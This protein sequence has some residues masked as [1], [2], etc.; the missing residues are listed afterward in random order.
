MGALYAGGAPT[1]LVQGAGASTAAG[2]DMNSFAGRSM[3]IGNVQVYD[4]A[5]FLTMNL[6]NMTAG[7]QFL[8][9]LPNKITEQIE[10]ERRDPM[11]TVLL[12]MFRFY[13]YEILMKRKKFNNALAVPIPW[14]GIANLL[15][16]SV[17]KFKASLERKGTAF[18][19]EGDLIRYIAEGKQHFNDEL[20]HIKLTVLRTLYKDCCEEIDRVQDYK[21]TWAKTHRIFDKEPDR[22]ER[23]E[24]REFGS[25]QHAVSG[26]DFQVLVE[27]SKTSMALYNGGTK[28]DSALI[29][30]RGGRLF[31]GMAPVAVPYE[32][33]GPDG[34]IVQSMQNVN[35]LA[36]LGG[37]NIY[38]FDLVPYDDELEAMDVFRKTVMIGQ[39][40][41][42]NTRCLCG[43]MASYKTY[44]ETIFI[45]EEKHADDYV[46]ILP[47]NAARYC[48]RF[49]DDG[50]LRPEHEQLAGL[51][52]NPDSVVG[53]FWKMKGCTQD[54]FI[55]K[56]AITHQYAVV[57]V[58]G[59]MAKHYLTPTCMRDMVQTAKNDF[60][61]AA[62]K[63]DKALSQLRDLYAASN[64]ET[65]TAAYM[66][67]FSKINGK[68]APILVAEPDSIDPVPRKLNK[69]TAY[70]GM[71]IP[72]S[73]EACEGMKTVPPFI[74]TFGMLN[75][76][77][78][79]DGKKWKA[80]REVAEEAVRVIHLMA[81]HIEG[82][83]PLCKIKDRANLP[84]WLAE[85]AGPTEHLTR[86]WAIFEMITGPKLPAFIKLKHE[87]PI[88][89]AA[90]HF[91]AAETATLDR[92]SVCGKIAAIT[93]LMVHEDF[94]G[95]DPTVLTA[96]N[97]G[98]PLSALQA[99]AAQ[100]LSV[101]PEM[102]WD[103]V[104][105]AEPQAAKIMQTLADKVAAARVQPLQIAIT[106]LISRVFMDEFIA[107][108][109]RLP[110]DVNIDGGDVS[111]VALTRDQLFRAIDAALPEKY[112][113]LVTPGRRIAGFTGT[114]VPKAFGEAVRQITRF[115]TKAKD[116]AAVAEQLLAHLAASTTSRNNQERFV[117]GAGALAPPA[118]DPNN[119]DY[120]AQVVAGYLGPA[121]LNFGTGHASWNRGR[122]APET[123]MTP[124]RDT[125]L[126]VSS[127]RHAMGGLPDARR[128]AAGAAALRVA[129]DYTG[130]TGHVTPALWNVSIVAD[131]PALAAGTILV[132][133][134]M[135]ANAM[136]ALNR[137]ILTGQL[138]ADQTIDEILAA[139]QTADLTTETYSGMPW[140]RAPFG[141]SKALVEAYTE[142]PSIYGNMPFVSPP[143][144]ANQCK[145]PIQQGT[146]IAAEL[147]NNIDLLCS[148]TAQIPTQVDG[149]DMMDVDDTGIQPLY[150]PFGLAMGGPGNFDTEAGAVVRTLA[151]VGREYEASFKDSELGRVLA[152]C[153]AVTPIEMKTV[154]A[155][156]ERNIVRP[157]S[158]VVNRCFMMMNTHPVIFMKAGSETGVTF[159]GFEGIRTG[160]DVQSITVRAEYRYY[161]APV[162]F[163]KENFLFIRHASVE[164][165]LT[166]MGTEPILSYADTP[167]CNPATSKDIMYYLCGY[168]DA[169]IEDPSDAYS[170]SKGMPNPFS[171]SGDYTQLGVGY[172]SSSNR[173]IVGPEWYYRLVFS[174][175]FER[176]L[177]EA[178]A[179]QAASTSNNRI[180]TIEY[181]G[182]YY[183]WNEATQDFSSFH[184]NTGHFRETDTMPGTAKV[185]RGEVGYY[186]PTYVVRTGLTV[187]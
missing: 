152:L 86:C 53:K 22:L 102:V 73:E 16:T 60:G 163:S 177:S 166:G 181:R 121:S 168:D 108:V 100:A 48:L 58:F 117:Q 170:K 17:E 88:D 85:F 123:I 133:T 94:G 82:M 110:A 159:L 9:V 144:I 80:A 145:T 31:G 107:T 69:V 74:N 142:A 84:E 39:W 13:A 125:D 134:M 4:R 164:D 87:R 67:E 149:D 63:I 185:R 137:A 143:D 171:I 184:Y 10:K 147:A 75:E 130:Y 42:M 61:D 45:H 118:A 146:A 27:E 186:P 99:R 101:V 2:L 162:I 176:V 113:P 57:D 6:G 71:A 76:L 182:E 79:T 132:R 62:I 72:T 124:S 38:Q 68:L 26:P 160:E 29:P 83:F 11:T 175:L 122:D 179:I 43:N 153:I 15:T 111:V 109:S 172:G 155:M 95:G 66:R 141:A 105:L 33:M 46:Q 91:P 59:Q 24:L 98:A 36:Q 161:S 158:Y 30:A 156:H 3:Q 104:E 119:V 52:N 1:T 37:V 49:Q 93:S 178:S 126:A 18:E 187:N 140:Y 12:P 103:V 44:K 21:I 128:G 81:D 131:M 106:R 32:V 20:N 148:R 41:P 14:Q 89:P 97:F 77:A 154:Q 90:A 183:Y 5:P 173:R 112:K 138:S 50:K 96:L 7:Q 92:M 151:R 114:T 174:E 35:A 55:Y 51:A 167:M 19:I 78:H 23:W 8:I 47:K 25:L 64:A 120:V 150:A 65:G 116:P 34:K 54:P 129:L 139:Y 40:Y 169:C 165:V 135:P 180:N 136:A 70:G 157:W 56:D 127:L 115:I 28:P